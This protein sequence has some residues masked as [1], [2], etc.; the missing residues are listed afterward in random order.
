M[1]G[2]RIG[3]IAAFAFC[4]FSLAYAAALIGGLLS[5]Q[6]P[7][8]PIGDPYFTCMEVLILLMA[9]VIVILFSAIH[10][11]APAAARP[12]S[13]AAVA[14]T[15]LLS[16]LTACVHFSV[17]TLGRNTAFV[18]PDLAEKLFAFRWPS[19]AYAL[20]ILAWDVFFPL[21]AFLAIPAFP[22]GR[23]T[24]LIKLALGVSGA[25][26]LA[27]LLGVTIGDM[28]IRNIGIV[29]YAAIFPLAVFMIGL[30]Y[31]RRESRSV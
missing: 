10:E 6:S 12:F 29:G 27:G 7:D 31:W 30:F 23:L 13:R 22:A 17:L 18:S 5:L 2:E 1:R 28:Q 9:P 11:N 14:F 4:A 8:E 21:A 16:G 19:L 15:A 3:A 25:L 24:R 26:A 20:D